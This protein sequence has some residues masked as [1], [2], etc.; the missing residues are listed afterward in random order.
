MNQTLLVE[1][2]EVGG[3]WDDHPTAVLRGFREPSGLDVGRE[4]VKQVRETPGEGGGERE[5]GRGGRMGG[6]GWVGEDE[7]GEGVGKRG[8]MGGGGRVGEDERGEGVG[9]RGE[10]RGS[11]EEGG[12]W[13]GKDERGGGEEYEWGE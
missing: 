2:K 13:V 11:G 4:L 1:H 3:T 9:K 6:G 10:G 5:W 7:R 12:G 8:R